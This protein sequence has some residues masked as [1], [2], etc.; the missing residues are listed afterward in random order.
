MNGKVLW[1]LVGAGVVLALDVLVGGAVV[2]VFL[3]TR[4]ATPLGVPAGGP[5]PIALHSPS[6]KPYADRFREL[7]IPAPGGRPYAL[8]VG[9]DGSVWF[10]ESE[11]TSGIGRLA[12]SGNWDN[13]KIT[14]GCDAQPLALTQG[15]D[16]NVWFADVWG[17]Y[18]RVTKDGLLTRFKLPDP[19]YA[20]G[21][22]TGPDHNLWLA[23][24][25]PYQ[26][27]YIAQ[28]S[29]LGFVI[30]QYY[31]NPK[32]GEARG[33]VTGPDGAL[34]FTEGNAIGRITT[35]GQLTEY[36]LPPGSTGMPYQIAAGPDHNIWFVEYTPGAGVI[37]RMKP[38]GRL[39]EFQA[40]G[41][42]GL[43]WIAP[44][45]DKALW[46]TGGGSIGRI[47]TS[48][49]VTTYAI[50]T[51]QV[52]PVGIATGPD[53]NI[54]FAESLVDGTGKLGIFSIK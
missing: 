7:P 11:C 32:A 20:L 19:S 40:V 12:R 37:G 39:T 35:S 43:Q 53:G 5:S 14:G 8:S 54:W 2:T 26:K 36:P 3:L 28:I 44:G 9:A 46:F 49:A 38:S 18:G 51:Y 45:P 33:I 27:P 29:P 25:S 4:H 16:G 34:W 47:T 48:G 23:A 31:I 10:T 13:W 15:P 50:P 30:A 1:A 21:I 52:Q 42:G 24:A 41:V 6:P 22:T 17:Y